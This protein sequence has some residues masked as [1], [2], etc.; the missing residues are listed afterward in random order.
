MNPN[1]DD[2]IEVDLEEDIVLPFP[3]PRKCIVD[4]TIRN[5]VINPHDLIIVTHAS[6]IITIFHKPTGTEV[7]A[8]THDQAMRK[9]RTRLR[10]HERTFRPNC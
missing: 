8:R 10:K 6:K 3:P 2:T 4:L 1:Y 9:L 5:M 7:H